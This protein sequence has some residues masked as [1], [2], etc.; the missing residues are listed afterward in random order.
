MPIY[1]NYIF[2]FSNLISDPA[3]LEHWF[4]RECDLDTYRDSSIGHDDHLPLQEVNE[5][6]DKNSDCK[7]ILIICMARVLSP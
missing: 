7:G 2:R 3:C 5:S 6:T 4:G 1:G